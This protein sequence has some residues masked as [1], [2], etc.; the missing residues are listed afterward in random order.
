MYWRKPFLNFKVGGQKVSPPALEVRIEQRIAE[1]TL[2]YISIHYPMDGQFVI[3]P[4]VYKENSL[5]EVKWGWEPDDL[6]TFY[7]YI[8]HADYI[9]ESPIRKQNVQV[10]YVLVGNGQALSVTRTKDWRNMTDSAIAKEIARK[11]GLSFVAHRTKR[12]HTYVY[13]DRKTDYAFLQERAAASG[14][15]C[16]VDNGVLYFVDPAAW[17]A[18]RKA[19]APEFEIHKS[20]NKW[21][22]IDQFRAFV[23]DDMPDPTGR[24][25]EHAAYGVDFKSERMIFNTQGDSKA[26]Q[27]VITDTRLDSQ[28]ELDFTLDGAQVTTQDYLTAQGMLKGSTRLQPGQPIKLKGDAMAERLKGDWVIT[29]TTHTLR[30]PINAPSAGMAKIDFTTYVELARNAPDTYNYR[31]QTA[32]LLNDACTEGGGKWRSSQMQE[33]IL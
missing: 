23:G 28:G 1:H 33:V 30:A 26:R 14:R 5:V 9:S 29:A 7:G 2:M 18:A 8:H 31:D 25:I 24:K 15:R 11:H 10:D 21:Y 22:H 17:A 12:V 4:K 16:W 19:T 27:E 20:G 13:Q 3:K 32:P 6:H